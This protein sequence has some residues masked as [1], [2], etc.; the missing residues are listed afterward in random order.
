MSGWISVDDRLPESEARVLVVTSNGVT[1]EDEFTGDS[2]NYDNHYESMAA[3]QG[4]IQCDYVTHW[5]P[6]PP[7]EDEQ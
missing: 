5:M 6:A 1:G 4:V 3:A 7:K 2:F